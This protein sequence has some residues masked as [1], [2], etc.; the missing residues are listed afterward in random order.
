MVKYLRN[1]NFGTKVSSSERWLVIGGAGFIGSNLVE[2][3]LRGNKDVVVV[4]NFSMGHNWI[5]GAKY[6]RVDVRNRRMISRIIRSGRF[7]VVVGAW[8]T[9]LLQS[10]E[11]PFLANNVNSLGAL[12]VLDVVRRTDSA[13]IYLSTGS[14]YGLGSVGLNKENGPTVPS[15]TYGVSKLAAEAYV[16]TYNLDYGLR[17]VILRL[18][19][20]YGPRQD[21]TRYGGV[22]A[23]FIKR[24]LTGRPP[25]IIGDGRETRPFLFVNDA[26]KAI[27]LASSTK[28]ANGQTI[29]VAGAKSY[30]IAQLAK[31]VLR[32]TNSNLKPVHMNVDRPHVKHFHSSLDNARKILG[33]TPKVNL[34]EGLRRTIEQAKAVNAPRV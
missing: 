31:L 15:T 3:L 32:L 25:T 12:N 18:H 8:A 4:D 30:S 11:N 2:E 6:L 33:F 16:R 5:E 34:Q 23:I 9:R 1:S 28:K 14:V 27:L 7:D 10:L 19:S 26:T 22:A 29:N 24:I 17:T 13:F 21:T 20:V